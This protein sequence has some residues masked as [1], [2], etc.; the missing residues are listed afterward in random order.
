MSGTFQL[1]T[2]FV[3]AGVL[4][5]LGIGVFRDANA[6]ALIFATL[7]WLVAYCHF[8]EALWIPSRGPGRKLVDRA[9]I[10]IKGIGFTLIALCAPLAPSAVSIVIGS[11]GLILILFGRIFWEL[12]I[13]KQSSGS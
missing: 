11:A 2:H 8:A 1:L 7:F 9:G 6:F 12:A 13:A 4:L 3:L 10:A 5:G